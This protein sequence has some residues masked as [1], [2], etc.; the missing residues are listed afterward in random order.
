M[1]LLSDGMH[2]NGLD[3]E[4]T[5]SATTS[6]RVVLGSCFAEAS[7]SAAGAMGVSPSGRLLALYKRTKADTPKSTSTP[8]VRAHPNVP[9]RRPSHPSL[10]P[11]RDAPPRTE[12]AGS[13]AALG[14][15]SFM[16]TRAVRWVAGLPNLNAPAPPAAPAH[17]ELVGRSNG[18][19]AC[20]AHRQCAASA[21]ACAQNQQ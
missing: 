12:V 6:E 20:Q 21:R 4:R 5:A 14:P 9:Q 19:R 17:V 10:A 3:G 18:R 15:K 13:P 7:P 8:K 1:H 11:P 16:M 2:G